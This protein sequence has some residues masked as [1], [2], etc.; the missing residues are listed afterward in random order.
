MAGNFFRTL[1][2]DTPPEGTAEQGRAAQALPAAAPSGPKADA[3]AP[4]LPSLAELPE[5]APLPDPVPHVPAGNSDLD[6]DIFASPVR[7]PFARAPEPPPAA[8]PP[9]AGA[10]RPPADL[11]S[12]EPRLPP[13]LWPADKTVTARVYRVLAIQGQ[14]LLRAADGQ[15]EIAEEDDAE[16][17]I[18]AIIPEAH[19][20]ICFL[21]SADLGLLHVGGDAGTS[22]YLSAHLL[23]SGRERIYMLRRPLT[24]GCFGMRDE[25]A[26][27]LTLA[28]NIAKPDAACL[29]LFAPSER[30]RVPAPV[31]KLA[32]EIGLA[33]SRPLEPMAL[34]AV[35][36]GGGM[37][38]S[39]FGPFLRLLPQDALARL[40]RQIAADPGTEA[41]I[42]R[43]L[44]EDPWA[45][46]VLSELCAWR[47]ERQDVPGH[48]LVSPPEDED[49][50]I[51][52]SDITRLSA[53]QVLVA[54]VRA[55][56]VPRR[57]LCALASARDEGI[58]LLDW[59]AYHRSVGFEHIF[60]YSN[61]NADGSDALLA[62]LAAAGVITWIDNQP[63]QQVG[64][65][66][67]A[68]AHALM[69]LPQI[70]DYRWTAMFD[71]DEFF[72]FDRA[73]FENATDVIAFHETQEV[74]ALAFSWLLF[75]APP[76]QAPQRGPVFHRFPTR[77]ARV[78]RHTKPVFRTSQFWAAH[79]HYPQPTLSRPF[80]YRGDNGELHHHPGVTDRVPAF[81]A[82]PTTHTAWFNH[83]MLR[84]APE[85]LMQA[86]RGW[87]DWPRGKPFPRQQ[88]LEAIARRF[89]DL[90]Q[91]GTVQPDQR[92][93]SCAAGFGDER[94]RL[95]ALPGVEAA[96]MAIN[97]KQGGR[98]RVAV[99][100]FLAEPP[101]PDESADLAQFRAILAEH[102]TVEAAERRRAAAIAAGGSQEEGESPGES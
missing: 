100:S 90:A 31:A 101:A 72:C 43:T 67:K 86:T 51:P 73:R 99:E 3:A 34:L 8:R 49:A 7:D 9:A 11:A 82:N 91:T 14:V 32:G 88:H 36:Q 56:T 44:A 80:I 21:V 94:A 74:D 69:R 83:Y 77:R 25:E 84:T 63:G 61:D 39:L 6:D 12:A 57:Y 2:G 65:Q 35:L 41:L 89:I 53:G 64:P 45:T 40:A 78:D 97:R 81:S 62:A 18:F 29:F 30:E 95:L 93:L 37:R 54:A 42:I 26:G 33:S 19:R 27:R 66:N 24:P 52:E 71:I 55:E 70:L 38:P 13:A 59:I 16:R 102:H 68:Y 17:G 1:F 85:A 58:Y 50:A 46:S 10:S 22:A 79:V 4:S 15:V 47:R 98:W 96:Y 28:G 92:I 23:R 5:P 75:G 48:R 20:Q 87:G 60:L 76:Q